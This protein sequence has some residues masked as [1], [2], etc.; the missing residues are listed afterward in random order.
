MTK[1]RALSLFSL[2]TLLAASGITAQTRTK[3]RVLRTRPPAFSEQAQT[4][5]HT[6]SGVEAWSVARANGFDFR[7]KQTGEQWVT[8]PYDGVNTT[9]HDTRVLNTFGYVTTDT[10]TLARVVGGNMVVDRPPAGSRSVTFALFGG[11]SLAEGW[12]VEDVRIRG[13][14]WK[15]RAAGNDLSIEVQVTAQAGR[16]ASARV[17]SVTLRGPAGQPWSAAFEGRRRWTINGIEAWAVAKE[18]GYEFHPVK[19]HDDEVLSNALDGVDTRISRRSGARTLCDTY[20]HARVVG[21]VMVQECPYLGD[22]G[23]RGIGDGDYDRTRDFRMFAGKVLAP[24]WIVRD[25]VA[26]GG[27]WVNRPES[28]DGSLEFT[29]RLSVVG[30]NQPTSAH[31]TRIVLEG[32]AS[33]SSWEDAFKVN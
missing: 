30:P 13:G 12:S 5:T 33:A 7:P 31:V 8:Y 16:S 3:N 23:R 28:G 26:S 1:S 29:Y 24:G 4:Q 18:Y 19:E 15:K 6:V 10:L 9:L 14:T 27:V 20:Y 17:E 11:G 25:V 22:D 2:M 32:P 21:G